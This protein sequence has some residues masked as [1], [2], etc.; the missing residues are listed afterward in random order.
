[1]ARDFNS[2]GS[3]RGNYEVMVRGTFANI[4]IR[5]KMVQGDWGYTKHFPSGDVLSIY[6]AASR[7]QSENIPTVVVAGKNTAPSS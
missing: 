1:M 6:E 4:K 2:Y 3:R 7:Y 5:N